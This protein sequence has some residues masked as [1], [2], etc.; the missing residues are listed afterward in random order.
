LF[1]YRLGGTED[2]LDFDSTTL[3]RYG[4]QEGSAK[5]YHPSRPGLRSHQPMLA[6]L[7][8]AKMIA[9]AWLR[10]GNSST[11]KGA[12]EFMR[13]TV[14]GLPPDLKIKCIRA[15]SGFMSDAILNT[16]E[17]MKLDFVI[18]A[19]MTQHLRRYCAGL[20]GWQRV[21]SDV[22]ISSGEFKPFKW[23]QARRVVVLR[24]HVGAPSPLFGIAEYDYDAFFTSLQADAA[25]VWKIYRGRGDCEN[26]IKELKND[27]GIGGFCLKSFIGTEVTFRL[28]CA[29]Y[30]IVAEFKRVALEDTSLTLG[31]IRHRIFVMGV[32]LGRSARRILLRLGLTGRWS[33]DFDLLRARIDAFDPTTPRP[34]QTTEPATPSLWRLRQ[35]PLLLTAN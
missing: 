21:S 8:G 17:E 32:A 5:G 22:E 25:D 31:T 35:P 15:D 14:A 6:M 26:R 28:L 10:C 13:E 23:A 33:R 11:L 1:D 19:K 12:A 20:S 18:A 34:P 7:A 24:R 2:I 3:T 30:N 29:L 16:I 9:H 4:S 27:F